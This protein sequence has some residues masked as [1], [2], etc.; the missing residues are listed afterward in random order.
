MNKVCVTP[1]DGCVPREL[2]LG[3]FFSPFFWH[4]EREV[5]V[6]MVI[7]LFDTGS[8]PLIGCRFSRFFV[9]STLLIGDLSFFLVSDLVSDF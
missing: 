9:L 3:F 4:V 5:W 6:F 1:L 2:V 8:Y 7:L